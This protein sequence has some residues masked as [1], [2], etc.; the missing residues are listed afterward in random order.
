MEDAVGTRNPVSFAFEVTSDFMSYSQGV[1]HRWAVVTETYSVNYDQCMWLGRYGQKHTK[2][3]STV[4][5]F[6]S[7]GES[8]LQMCF[9][10]TFSYINF[11]KYVCI[12]K[13][14]LAAKAI[15]IVYLRKISLLLEPWRTF[16]SFQSKT[17]ILSD[18]YELLIHSQLEQF[19]R[20]TQLVSKNKG[21]KLQSLADN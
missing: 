9:K 12:W 16:E 11:Y 18:R 3:Q 8:S 14:K 19:S 20:R 2:V 7:N 10:C 5:E 15:F 21:H 4:K 13:L 6:K 17:L 1:Y